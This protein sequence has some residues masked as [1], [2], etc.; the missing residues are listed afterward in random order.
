M[1]TRYLRWDVCDVKITENQR[2]RPM[3]ADIYSNRVAPTYETEIWN[4]RCNRPG[5]LDVR[6]DN[7]MKLTFR[8]RTS[9]MG[10]LFIHVLHV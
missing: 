6:A 1:A 3:A 9:M 2:M 7:P 5:E 8:Q 4:A 10:G